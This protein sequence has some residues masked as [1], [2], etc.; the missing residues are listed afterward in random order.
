MIS[1]NTKQDLAGSEALLRFFGGGGPANPSSSRS[2]GKVTTATTTTAAS[3][4][5]AGG[6]KIRTEVSK[7]I[8]TTTNRA[9]N[10]TVRPQHLV[11]SES[12]RPSEKVTYVVEP[13]RKDVNFAPTIKSSTDKPAR[14][15]S[16][17]F[18]D[19]MRRKATEEEERRKR[20]ARRI[21]SMK[22]DPAA[23]KPTPVL[24]L[25]SESKRSSANASPVSH[26]APTS[27]A[28]RQGLQGLRGSLHRI[29]RGATDAHGEGVRQASF[30]E[31][32][33]NVAEAHQGRAAAGRVSSAV[34]AESEGEGVA[35]TGKLR[36]K[37]RF[38]TSRQGS[39]SSP[40][41]SHQTSDDRLA[42]TPSSKLKKLT[43]ALRRAKVEQREGE[44]DEAEWTPSFLPPMPEYVAP[45]SSRLEANRAV[46]ARGGGA[47]GRVEAATFALE[48]SSP[49][50]GLGRQRG[51]A[52]E[53]EE[54]GFSD[55][56]PLTKTD[57]RPTGPSSWNVRET[58][59]S[60]GAALS[61]PSKTIDGSR[62]QA[63]IHSNTTATGV[64]SSP[65]GRSIVPGGMNVTSEWAAAGGG[66][67]SQSP[68]STI[69]PPSTADSTS[70]PPPSHPEVTSSSGIERLDYVRTATLV[71][72]RRDPR[73]VP[74]FSSLVRPGRE[75]SRLGHLDHR[76]PHQD[77]ES[78]AARLTRPSSSPM[79]PRSPPIRYR[80]GSATSARSAAPRSLSTSSSP[81]RPSERP[82]PTELDAYLSRNQRDPLYH[83]LPPPPAYSEVVAERVT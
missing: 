71:D 26:Q 66:R 67:G 21:Q 31:K 63:Q 83:L 78:R 34:A 64:V 60:M 39:S 36:A 1:H 11:V 15:V 10:T 42:K 56:N 8:K 46:G 82:S 79:G 52:E 14:I 58:Y 48:Y 43:S 69:T 29:Q 57:K 28:P 3:S 73:P 61:R 53:K 33:G 4:R 77:D 75:P 80:P 68:L 20:R 37:V 19:E 72:G 45:S 24:R 5:G 27:S 25:E 18:Q 74:D 70:R 49:Q 65:S 12:R 17:A 22:R 81:P 41:P 44:A 7:T 9:T 23:M 13:P 2:T 59:S 47:G 50:P 76:L 16:K 38:S 30:S 62:E 55:S 35:G 54:E 51:F 40:P 32:K 6:T